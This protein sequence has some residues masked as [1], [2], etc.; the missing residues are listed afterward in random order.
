MNISVHL[1]SAEWAGYSLSF[2][3]RTRP[4]D[5]PGVHTPEVA[6]RWWLRECSKRQAGLQAAPDRADVCYS[7][8][9]A[10]LCSQVARRSGQ[11]L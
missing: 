2:G 5:V 4:R 9:C 1:M 8:V 3:R 11:W 6:L 10:L 7:C